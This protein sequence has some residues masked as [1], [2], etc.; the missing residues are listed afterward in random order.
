MSAV[1][2][3]A[4][5]TPAEGKR[6]AVLDALRPAIQAV[7]HE[8]GCELYAIHDHPNG[9]IVMIEKWTSTELL[10][11]HGE[12]LPVAALNRALET[13]LAGPVVV[14]RLTPIPVGDEIRG[15]L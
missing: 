15:A 4:V 5:F 9:D 11:A 6:A 12:G 3:T 13:L 14:T 7:H 10:D 2:V 8:P 1:V